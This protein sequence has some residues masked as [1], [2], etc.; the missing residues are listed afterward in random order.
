[1]QVGMVVYSVDVSSNVMYVCINVPIVDTFVSRLMVRL[2]PRMKQIFSS[3][4]SKFMSSHLSGP[5]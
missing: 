1:M 4:A 2:T 5:K 3:I